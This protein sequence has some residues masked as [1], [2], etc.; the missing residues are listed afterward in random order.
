MYRKTVISNYIPHKKPKYPNF[1]NWFN[2]YKY[3]L[4]CLFG[5][6]KEN[7]EE[8]YSGSINNDW[9]SDELFIKFC[10]FIYTKSSKHITKW[11]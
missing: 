9:N 10:R 7:I 2:E 3:S 1:N 5:I 8:R 11:V 6:L 4:E